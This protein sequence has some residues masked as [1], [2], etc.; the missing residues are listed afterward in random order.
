MGSVDKKERWTTFKEI[1]DNFIVKDNCPP[2][3]FVFDQE[4]KF[5]CNR[6]NCKRCMREYV[7]E[8]I[9]I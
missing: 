7:E 1:V 4:H 6:R 9:F 8:N 2:A 3:H 5:K